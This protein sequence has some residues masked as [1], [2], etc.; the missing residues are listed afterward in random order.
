MIDGKRFREL[1]EAAMLTQEELADRVGVARPVITRAESEIKDLSLGVA[2]AV[3]RE[4]GCRIDDF[5]RK[6]GAA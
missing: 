5:I 6:G 2:A 3:A 4:L 1:R